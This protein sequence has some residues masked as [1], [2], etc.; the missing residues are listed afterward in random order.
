MTFQNRALLFHELRMG[1]IDLYEDCS[2][3]LALDCISAVCRSIVLRLWNSPLFPRSDRAPI[4]TEIF[5]HQLLSR[6]RWWGREST[7]DTSPNAP[8]SDCTPM[9]AHQGLG[10]IWARREIGRVASREQ[11][12]TVPPCHIAR[13][14][15]AHPK[16]DKPDVF[17]AVQ[18][19]LLPK[20]RHKLQSRWPHGHSPSSVVYSTVL[21]VSTVLSTSVPV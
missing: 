15:S 2:L 9:N 17:L 4:L 5:V 8:V 13:V 7:R 10:E 1:E 12:D 20:L 11:V 14:W 18:S 6:Y 21:A 19:A 16:A 3:H